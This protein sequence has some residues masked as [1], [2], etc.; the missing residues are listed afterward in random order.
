MCYYEM[1][2]AEYF[3]HYGLPIDINAHR[4]SIGLPPLT[5]ESVSEPELKPVHTNGN[6]VLALI[7]GPP[8]PLDALAEAQYANLPQ[9]R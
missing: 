2:S 4:L 5:D 6:A 3:N 9:P 7:P 1:M 8:D